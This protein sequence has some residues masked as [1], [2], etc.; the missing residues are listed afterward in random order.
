M[1]VFLMD[2]YFLVCC[3]TQMFRYVYNVFLHYVWRRLLAELRSHQFPLSADNK[4]A[5]GIPWVATT[6]NHLLCGVWGFWILVF[7][8]SW[9]L[10]YP[11]S[12]CQG[13]MSE[14]LW[15]DH[16]IA[17]LLSKFLGVKCLCPVLCVFQILNAYITHMLWIQLN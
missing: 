4:L 12:P 5:P 3:C 2:V 15:S 7:S 17:F 6:P 10:L 13:W 14:L 9:K 16:V 1:R 11:L 8:L